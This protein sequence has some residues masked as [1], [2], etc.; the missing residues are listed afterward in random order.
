[1]ALQFPRVWNA[2]QKWDMKLNA[3]NVEISVLFSYID[4]VNGE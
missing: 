1:M 2:T 3:F 4:F